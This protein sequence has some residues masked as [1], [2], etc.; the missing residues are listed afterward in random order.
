MNFE[1]MLSARYLKKNGMFFLKKEEGFSFI[2]IEKGV[3]YSI[4]KGCWVDLPLYLIAPDLLHY[5]NEE[6]GKVD[7]WKG[8]PDADAIGLFDKYDFVL[9]SIY[10]WEKYYK[11][12]VM[13]DLRTKKYPK[14]LQPMKSVYEYTDE[15][16]IGVF[17]NKIKTFPATYEVNA[18]IR[19]A[20]VADSD[21]KTFFRKTH[22]G[23]KDGDN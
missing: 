6:T 16:S 22:W 8:W 4:L 18:C 7:M 3:Y 9:P 12:T 21:R 1:E 15:G 2:V 11:A 20:V 17:D 14:S 23:Y 10:M 5:I 19:L 13:G